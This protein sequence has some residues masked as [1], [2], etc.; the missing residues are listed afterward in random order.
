MDDITGIPG[1][2][3]AFNVLGYIEK[4]LF[5]GLIP[6]WLFMWNVWNPLKKKKR[7]TKKD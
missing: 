4:I 5:F 1:M 7:K 6:L 2:N 3:N